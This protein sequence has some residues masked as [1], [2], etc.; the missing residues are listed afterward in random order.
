[1]KTQFP[2][3]RAI[4]VAGVLLPLGAATSASAQYN[5]FRT[6]TYGDALRAG[7]FEFY[8]LGQYWRAEDSTMH[9]ITL[10][11]APPPNQVLET[12]DLVMSFDE[13]FG[14]GFGLG[15]HLNSHFTVRGEFSFGTP[16]YTLTFNGLTGKGEAFI[17]S[18]KF[19]L[20]YNIIRGP[21]TPFVS[22]GLGY[23]YIDSGV[24]SGSTQYWCWWDYWWG[25]VCE[26]YTPTHTATW[27]T[28]N[29][30]AGVR[31]DINERVFLRVSAGANWLNTDAD[32][33][34]SIEGVVAV[35]W[36]Y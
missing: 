16:D 22:A 35:G 30:L 26:G 2:I 8:L 34:T 11:T 3:S 4:L 27:F 19:N 29:A 28:V 18:G 10:E 7:R 6:D 25:Y 5:P 13:S 32:W 20:D 23:F 14:W 17:S 15:Y 1:M 36:K 21:V 9:N 31:W 24:P 12:G 33:I